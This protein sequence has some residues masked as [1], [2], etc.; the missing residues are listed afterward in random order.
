MATKLVISMDGI[1]IGNL[2]TIVSSRSIDE[3]ILVNNSSGFNSINST[4][5]SAI[6]TAK[7]SINNAGA[8]L[9]VAFANES[10]AA[11]TGSG[12]DNFYN[13]LTSNS[14]PFFNDPGLESL[15]S[16]LVLEDSAVSGSSIVSANLSSFDST[17]FTNNVLYSANTVRST[18]T[19][20]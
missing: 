16:S 11:F 8:T 15:S 12:N 19:W 13:F 2:N 10:T 4:N 17:T 18:N 20:K 6:S 9:S 5:R 14:I 3:V 1:S 7:T